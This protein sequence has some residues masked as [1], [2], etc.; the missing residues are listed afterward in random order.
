M[1][2]YDNGSGF[3]VCFNENDASDFSQLWPCSTV[4]G[5]GSF[6]FQENGDLIDA[7][8]AALHCDGHDWS[9]FAEDCKKFGFDHIGKLR[10]R[11]CKVTTP[12]TIGD[13]CGK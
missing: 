2:T 12:R 13:D 3:T 9:A 6:S 10:K 11:N 5:K 8:G 1:R 4:E 7:S